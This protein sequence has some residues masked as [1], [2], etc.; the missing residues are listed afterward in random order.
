MSRFKEP[1]KPIEVD[2]DPSEVEQEL[3]VLSEAPLGASS[4]IH[5]QAIGNSLTP[6]P[7]VAEV[8]ERP[9]PPPP[10]P[11]EKPSLEIASEPMRDKPPLTVKRKN[12]DNSGDLYDTS[13]CPETGGEEEFVSVRRKRRARKSQ[14]PP[15]PPPLL[16]DNRF[17]SLD[18]E[19][20]ISN[21]SETDSMESDG[22][23]VNDNPSTIEDSLPEPTQVP[24]VPA[25]PPDVPDTLE[26]GALV[27]DETSQDSI[28]F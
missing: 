4:P 19:T 18:R 15:P 12:P 27:I 2:D 16:T 10:D 22:E 3:P 5:G 24:D 13:S 23:P 26:S 25:I 6:T 8:R 28:T 20:N 7:P 1:E 14:S 17:E 21:D 9:E 11:G